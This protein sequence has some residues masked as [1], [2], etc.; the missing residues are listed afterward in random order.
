MY[1][2]VCVCV[3]VLAF[4][5]I[6]YHVNFTVFFTVFLSNFLFPSN[7]YWTSFFYWIDAV[8]SKHW[9]VP[10]LSPMRVFCTSLSH[11]L[12]PMRTL[13]VLFT[14]EETNKS[15]LLLICYYYFIY[16]FFIFLLYPPLYFC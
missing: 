14:C 1:V 11:L 12:L 4:T 3:C 16:L 15:K 5:S 13:S 7:N 2:C 8:N 6:C 9:R 10:R